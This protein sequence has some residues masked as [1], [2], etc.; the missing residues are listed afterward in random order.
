MGN[1]T[2]TLIVLLRPNPIPVDISPIISTDPSNLVVSP[3]ISGIV[4]QRVN[5]KLCILVYDAVMENFFELISPGYSHPTTS[6]RVNPSGLS[7]G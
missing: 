6:V 7:A 5:K 4:A 1:V 3:L 2:P